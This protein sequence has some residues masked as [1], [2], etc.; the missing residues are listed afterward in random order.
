MLRVIAA[1]GACLRRQGLVEGTGGLGKISRRRID[2]TY[3]LVAEDLSRGLQALGRG[4]DP[5]L[6]AYTTTYE[7]MR[8]DMKQ[9]TAF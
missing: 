1:A 9:V 5:K 4:T 3:K 7:N 6:L 8:P 2:A